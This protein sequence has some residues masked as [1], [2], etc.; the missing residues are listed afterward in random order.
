VSFAELFILADLNNDGELN[1]TEAGALA[2]DKCPKVFEKE[3]DTLDYF[4]AMECLKD[5]D[6]AN[7]ALNDQ[8]LTASELNGGYDDEWRNFATAVAA[9]KPVA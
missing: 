3:G 1:Q 9:L 7:N 4:E 6:G 2:L 8:V 5:H